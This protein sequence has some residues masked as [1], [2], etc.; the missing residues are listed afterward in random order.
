M[1]FHER[2]LRLVLDSQKATALL[3]DLEEEAA[4]LGA[5]RGWIRRQALRCALSAAWLAVQRRRGARPAI[6]PWY[7]GRTRAPI[8]DSR[9]AVAK[10]IPSEPPLPVT[11]AIRSSSRNGMRLTVTDHAD[12]TDQAV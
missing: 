9:R 4:R 7:S 2:L 1:T 6:H 11:R 8:A 5:S 3:G 10:P 12:M